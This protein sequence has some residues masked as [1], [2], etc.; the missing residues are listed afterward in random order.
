VIDPSRPFD[1]LATRSGETSAGPVVSGR[2]YDPVRDDV[3]L[4]IAL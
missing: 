4:E 3:A 1:W 2:K